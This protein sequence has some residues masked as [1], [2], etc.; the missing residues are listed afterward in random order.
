MVLCGS[1]FAGRKGKEWKKEGRDEERGGEG[2]LMEGK[3]RGGERGG[4][5]DKDKGRKVEGRGG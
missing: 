5:E 3:W 2:R 1:H 4:G